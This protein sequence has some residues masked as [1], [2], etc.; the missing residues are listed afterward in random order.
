VNS[1]ASPAQD[2]AG[3]VA[4]PL[5]IVDRDGLK[6]RGRFETIHSFFA[7]A[8]T[9][10]GLA[11]LDPKS[12]F[13]ERRAWGESWFEPGV[14]VTWRVSSV[15]ELYGSLSVGASRTW[16]ADAFDQRNQGEFS[17]ENAFAGFRTIRPADQLNID[18]SS[19]QQNYSVGTGMLILARRRQW[20]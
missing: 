10:F 18:I 12:E 16:G 4:D 14:D 3:S 11:A 13:S 6:V 1:V 8:G 15:L 9:W 20:L 19:G 7:S 2:A 17:L 5:V